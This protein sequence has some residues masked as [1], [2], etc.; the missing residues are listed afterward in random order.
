V[1]RALDQLATVG[2]VQSV[3]QA[4]ARRWMT[5]LVPGFSTILLLPGPLPND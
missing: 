3:G 5:P 1:Q 2:K 4:R